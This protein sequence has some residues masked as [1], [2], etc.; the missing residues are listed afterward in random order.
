MK[1]VARAQIHVHLHGKQ[2]DFSMEP[3]LETILQAALDA[4]IPLPYSCMGGAC[5]SCR[6]RLVEG[7]VAMDCNYVLAD[8]EVEANLIL[9]CQARPLSA[10]VVLDCTDQG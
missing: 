5:A 9:T 8:E 4:D 2:Y 6:A 1:P 3:E 10:K 7:E